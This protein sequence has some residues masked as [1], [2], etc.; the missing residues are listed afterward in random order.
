MSYNPYR[1]YCSSWWK[2][3]LNLPG[4]IWEFLVRMRDYAPLL[5]EDRD[6]DYAYLLH[7][8]KFKL[9]RMRPVINQGMA[10]HREQRAIEIHQAEVM[11]DN[12]FEDP[13]DEWSMHYDQW[14]S[15]IKAFKDCK[16]RKEHLKALRLTQKREE[17]NWKALWAHLDK[18]LRGWWD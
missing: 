13:D 10:A 3:W 7:M 2:Y 15:H 4:D 16:N 12:I 1:K 14:D 17:R 8:M 5:W 11:I 6:W 18:N 9:K